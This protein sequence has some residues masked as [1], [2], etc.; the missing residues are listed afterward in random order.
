MAINNPSDILHLADFE[1][2]PVADEKCNDASVPEP[3][4]R[5]E[6]LVFK[7]LQEKLHWQFR[8]VFSNP[9]QPRSVVVV[10]SLSLNRDELA[11]IAGVNHYEERLL[12]M[13]M[14]L[15]L[16]RTR[17][18]YLTSEP[19]SPAVI[20]YFLHLLPGIPTTH[21]RKRLLLL[22]CFDRSPIPLTEKI[23]AR[24]RLMHR[25]R[26]AIPDQEAGHLTCFNSTPLERTL[27]VRLGLPLYASDPVLMHLGSKSGC[28]GIFKKAGITLANGYENLK[29][30]Q[31]IVEG[32]TELKKRN[33]ALR[34]AVIKLNEGFSGE[35]NA[36]FSYEG[37]PD[38]NELKTWVG[39][40][41]PRRIAF[42]APRETWEKYRAKYQ[43]MGGIVEAFIEGAIKRSPSVQCRVNPL[44][45]AE[46]I[47]THDQVLGG[48]SGQVFMGCTFPAD[49]AYRVTLQERASGIAQLLRDE[50]VLGRFGI[51][52]ISVKNDMGWQHFAVEINLRKGGTTHP[53]LMLQFLTDGVFELDSGLYRTPAGDARYYYASDN[54][55]LPATRGLTPEDLVDISVDHG[56][57]FHGA[58][59]E[60]VVFHL[61]GA[62]SEFGKIGVLCVGSNRERAKALY[63]QTSSVL[64]NEGGRM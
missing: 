63:D 39:R 22:S 30:E 48:P 34:R 23:L 9:L 62:L 37:A 18:I 58:T 41:L 7:Q 19:I 4:S 8:E 3:G 17:L 38:G 6:L 54:L 45:E 11:K 42:E 24:P 44:G 61:I 59:Q 14:L 35:G 53:F 28:R 57:H 25:I 33:P 31:E 16:P 43:E 29:Q 13:L 52:F 64:E 49:S 40:E 15:R 5:Q 1:Y 10:P 60:G 50:G 21:A 51:D 27:A 36:L 26:Q 56:L 12:C 2:P 46:V 20:D 55:I 47:S 32:L